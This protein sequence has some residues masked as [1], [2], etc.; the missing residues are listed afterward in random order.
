MPKINKA[1]LN[2]EISVLGTF[3]IDPA[4]YFEHND[5]LCSDMFSGKQKIIAQELFEILDKKGEVDLQNFAYRIGNDHDGQLTDQDVLDLVQYGSGSSA[6]EFCKEL[7]RLYLNENE[8]VFAQKIM[9]RLQDGEDA[10]EILMDINNERDLLHENLESK[11]D[12]RLSDLMEVYDNAVAAKESGNLV[13]GVPTPITELSLLTSGWQPTDYN[14]VA[15]RP[16]MG[17]TSFGLQCARV[18][19]ERGFPC[20]FV[21]LEMSNIQLYR[22]LVSMAAHIPVERIRNGDL[23]DQ[24]L[25]AIHEEI[26]K[27]HALPLYVDDTVRNVDKIVN[28]IRVFKRKYGLELVVVDYLQLCSVTKSRGDTEDVGEISRKLSGATSRGDCNLSMIALAQLNR[29]LEKRGNKRPKL[30]DLRNSG[31]IEQDAD[32]VVFIYRDEYYEVLEDEYGNSLKNL[33][34]LI[35]AKNRHGR[36]KNIS[37]WLFFY[38]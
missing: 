34:E 2:M 11:E 1:R 8:M 19:A 33:A 30:Q 36:L 24:E 21:S 35:V 29:D 26:Q 12:T 37:I 4:L 23:S 38:R 18:S 17:K 14:V 13:T 9:F 28:K 20:L 32:T 31:Q 3:L 22:K 15:S 25:N 10:G 6:P 27:L 5:I 16:G 7:K